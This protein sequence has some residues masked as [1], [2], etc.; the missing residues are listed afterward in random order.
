MRR[1]TDLVA[2]KDVKNRVISALEARGGDARLRR[3]SGLV[4]NPGDED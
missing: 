1:L 4:E 2:Q 3:G